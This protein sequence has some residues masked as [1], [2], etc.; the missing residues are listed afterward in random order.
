MTFDL[1]QDERSVVVSR[2][3]ERIVGR[4]PAETARFL[5]EQ[6]D[7]FAN[8][9]GAALREEL[10]PLVDG[11]LDGCNLADLAPSLDRVVRIR[12]LQDMLPSQAVG[13]VLDLKELFGDVV[14]DDVSDVAKR[15]L[16]D[17]VDE[18]LLVAFDVYNACRQQVF[19]IRVREIRNRSMKVMERLNA[20]REQRAG[21]PSSSA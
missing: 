6:R 18:L 13:F 3:Y 1:S 2:W 16:D 10:S 9:V 11:L 5:K 15:D 19:D 4:Y 7:P 12:A 14:T 20:W 17:R 21:G 8:P